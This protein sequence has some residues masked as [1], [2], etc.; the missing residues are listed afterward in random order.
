MIDFLFL[1]L[2]EPVRAEKKKQEIMAFFFFTNVKFTIKTVL[3]TSNNEYED[4]MKNVKDDKNGRYIVDIQDIPD[5]QFLENTC[6]RL[7]LFPR[8]CHWN[9]NNRLQTVTSQSEH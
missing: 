8:Y 3:K 6:Q 4:N 1:L 2:K 7:A 5:Q 9:V